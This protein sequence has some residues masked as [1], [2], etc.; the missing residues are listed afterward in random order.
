MTLHNSVDTHKNNARKELAEKA[1][2]WQAGSLADR[3]GLCFKLGVIVALAFVLILLFGAVDSRAQLST[4]TTFGNVTDPSGAAI[5]NASV[6][7]TQ[8]LTNFTRATTTNGRG[9]YRA[10]FLP[11]GP[12]SIKVS[13]TGFK[14]V[15][16]KGVVLTAKPH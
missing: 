2:G 11:V 1:S 6:V 10:E 14:E 4:A 15:V 12:Y 5:P 9:E 8:T 7:L 3:H 16:Q 13:A